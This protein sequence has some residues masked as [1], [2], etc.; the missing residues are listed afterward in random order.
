MDI[1]IIIVIL[2][3]RVTVITFIRDLFQESFENI[4]I[5]CWLTLAL[6]L[7]CFIILIFFNCYLHCFSIVMYGAVVSLAV[8]WRL[9]SYHHHVIIIII[10]VIVQV[11]SYIGSA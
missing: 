2:L 4:P 11:I 5:C 9:R 1:A 8:L 6:S 3:L 7:L 10:I